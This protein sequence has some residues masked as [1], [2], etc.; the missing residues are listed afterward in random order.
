MNSNSML[1]RGHTDFFCI[2]TEAVR[3]HSCRMPLEFHRLRYRQ[4]EGPISFSSLF[5][6]FVWKWTKKQRIICA[7]HLTLCA[8]WN[9]SIL[10]TV[11]QWQST[12]SALRTV[13]YSILYLGE[14]THNFITNSSTRST[15]ISVQNYPA[16]PFNFERPGRLARDHATFI[17]MLA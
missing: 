14:Q 16:A 2:S 15:T 12:S 1:E 5:Y 7:P 3:A 4:Q 6:L 11:P 10:R 17:V 9:V 13:S 8:F